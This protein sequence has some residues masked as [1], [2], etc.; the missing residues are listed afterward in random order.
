MSG[1]PPARS[2][3]STSRSSAGS[4]PIGH[5]ITGN[6]LSPATARS[7]GAGWEFVHVAVDDHSRI[8]CSQILPDEKQASAVGF[9][10]D[11]VRHYAHLGIKVDRVMTD[12]GSCYKSRAFRRACAQLGLKHIRDLS[13]TPRRPTA[14]PSASFRP[15]CG[16]GPTPPPSIPPMSGAPSCRDGCIATIGIDRM[17]VSAAS[18]PSAG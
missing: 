18:H 10:N 7:V 17:L 1:K 5:R 8:A 15:R 12:N 11:V 6:R 13:H 2:F 3:I 14:R 4:M 16:N 9:L